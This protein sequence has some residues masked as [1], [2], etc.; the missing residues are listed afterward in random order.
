MG[1]I[2]R[3]IEL[4]S[5]RVW[6]FALSNRA[7]EYSTAR[8]VR[9]WTNSEIGTAMD[10]IIT[11]LVVT[12]SICRLRVIRRVWTRL[13]FALSTAFAPDV[14]LMD[15]W[16]GAGSVFQDKARKRMDPLLRCRNH[17]HCLTQP[18]VTE[19]LLQ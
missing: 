4:F 1:T 9:G 17:H 2:E 13:A 14:L 12:S 18:R 7:S 15:E 16:I 8:F 11:F 6:G 3:V 10:D 19:T 5:I